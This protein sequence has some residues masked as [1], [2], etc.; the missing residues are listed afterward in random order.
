[1]LGASS[2][3]ITLIVLARIVSATVLAPT[4]GEGDTKPAGAPE[5]ASEEEPLVIVP[6]FGAPEG[7]LN[8][9]EGT[10]S[11]VGPMAYVAMK[12]AA[13]RA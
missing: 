11:G 8:R 13:W 4:D 10:I 6:V 2:A 12:P 3:T 7:R 9:P 5:P 1:M